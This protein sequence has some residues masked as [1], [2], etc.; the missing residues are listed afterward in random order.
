[1]RKINKHKELEMDNTQR[2]LDEDEVLKN[3]LVGWGA[4][5]PAIALSVAL[6]AGVFSILLGLA[7]AAAAMTYRVKKNERKAVEK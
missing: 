5:L 4:A 2:K 7:A 3:Q 1:M 6:G